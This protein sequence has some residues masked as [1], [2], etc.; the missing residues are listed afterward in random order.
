ME[1]FYVSLY[2]LWVEPAHPGPALVKDHCE[3]HSKQNTGL[4]EIGWLVMRGWCLI[5]GWIWW[6]HEDKCKDPKSHIHQHQQGSRWE[7]SD[8]R[9]SGPS[10][11]R[12]SGLRWTRSWQMTDQRSGLCFFGSDK[13]VWL[14]AAPP[15]P[16]C[17]TSFLDHW[18]QTLSSAEE[19]DPK[20]S[21]INWPHWQETKE[22]KT[23]VQNSAIKPQDWSS[24]GAKSPL[25]SSLNNLKTRSSIGQRWSFE[26]RVGPYCTSL[27]TIHWAH[28]QWW[29]ESIML[30]FK[31]PL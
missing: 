24:Y 23:E 13:R 28:L 29:A 9:L 21:H 30:L 7:E 8:E 15:P 25:S 6:K 2:L 22:K 4:V 19:A 14:S 10:K 31:C 17:F 11:Q 1:I 3:R 27:I 20:M 12:T 5:L 26:T 16:V 18:Y